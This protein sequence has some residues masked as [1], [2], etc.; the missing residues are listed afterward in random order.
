MAGWLDST[1]R[2]LRHAWRALGRAP[3]FSATVVL[4]LGMGIGASSAVFS[5][6]DAVLLHALPFPDSDQLVR[7]AQVN[8]RVPEPFVAPVRLEEWNRLNRTFQGISGYYTNDISE[9]S[10]ELPEKLTWALVAP[11]FLRVWR[12]APLLGRDFTPQEERYG[13]PPVVL[14]SERLWHRRFGGAA[15]VL[16][17]T[18]HIGRTNFAVVGVLPAAFLF[19]VGDTDVWSP[20]PPD[21]PYAQSREATWFTAIGRLKAGVTLAQA[22][23][24]LEAVQAGLG[25]AYPRTDAALHPSADRL[26]ESMVGGVRTSLWVLFG[27]VSLLL[28][29]ACTNVAALLLS[30]SAGRRQELS[31]RCA[32]GASR[33]AVTSRVLAEVA[34]LALFGGALG[35]A[36]ASAASSVFRSLAGALPRVG[37]IGLNW[38]V[39]CF[40]LGCAVAAT[41]ACGVIASAHG[42]RGNLAEL[43]ARAAVTT[44]EGRAD[45]ERKMLAEGRWVTPGYFTALRVPIVQG[46]T[47]REESQMT[48]VMVN[49][50]FVAAYLQ[51]GAVVG[52]RLLLV[53]SPL[54]DPGEIRGVVGDV[55]ERGLDH[56]AVP[57]VYWCAGA[58]QPGTFFLARTHG[59]PAA[60]AEAVRRRLREVEPGRSVYDL[61]PLG[62]HLSTAYGEQRLRTALLTSFA[63]AAL[64]LAGVGPYGTL[65]YL[66]FLRRREMAVRL[67]MGALR[68]QVV[69]RVLTRGLLVS[70][71]GCGVGLLLA[72]A[73]GRLLSGMLYGVSVTDP[74]ALVSAVGCV[75]V[76]SVGASLLPAL[77]ASRLDPT[78][79]LRES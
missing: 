58:L 7:L 28:L 49:R 21:A 51:T 70:L 38:A 57:T 32:L 17:R 34:V 69:R 62:A 52:R 1:G 73:L 75:L 43:F 2:D 78:E 41:F 64:A 67:A 9:L 5:A 48:T 63:L 44:P 20:S 55:R 27:S 45:S 16:T 59:A 24:D 8:A 12:V 11:R 74:T 79:L 30:R 4:T 3:V 33:A 68:A 18:L 72:F 61:T 50:A 31:L 35:L 53:G 25:R 66:V 19:P 13:G 39:V 54:Q 14:I 46:E 29:I 10:G 77:R 71:L 65:S 42:S 40:A 37:E 23:A 6:L 47:C 15:D 26:K 36:V 76:V 60:M 22:R 56:E